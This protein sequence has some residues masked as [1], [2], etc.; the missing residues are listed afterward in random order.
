MPVRIAWLVRTL[1]EIETALAPSC[2]ANLPRDR[3]P[4]KTTPF[5]VTA[6]VALATAGCT[7]LDPMPFATGKDCFY[8]ACSLSVEV[9]D[10]GRGGKRLKVEADGNVRMGTRHRLTAIVWN[11]KTPGYEFRWDS[12]APYTGRQTPGRPPTSY[13]TWNAQIVPHPYGTDNYSVTDINNERGILHYDITVYPDRYTPG[14]PITLGASIAND[15][16]QGRES[17]WMFMK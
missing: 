5:A 3:Q 1:G 7:T 15:G 14:E 11:L 4:M 13:G 16:F 8:P 17:G 9:V 10:D 12:I 2:R 6:A